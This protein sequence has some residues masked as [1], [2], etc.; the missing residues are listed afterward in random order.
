[1]APLLAAVEVRVG[2]FSRHF[3]QNDTPSMVVCAPQRLH[4]RLMSVT[5]VEAIQ[6][7]PAPTPAHLYSEWLTLTQ[8]SSSA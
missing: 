4:L 2:N 5:P 8:L 7:K 1:M 6:T 3:Q